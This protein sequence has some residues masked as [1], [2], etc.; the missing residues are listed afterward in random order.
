MSLVLLHEVIAI[1]LTGELEDKGM[2]RAVLSGDLAE[3]SNVMTEYQ[4]AQSRSSYLKVLDANVS[5]AFS[6]HDI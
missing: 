2:S 1:L 6:H 4:A 3:R 5:T